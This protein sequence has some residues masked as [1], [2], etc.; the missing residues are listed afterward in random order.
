MCYVAAPG[1]LSRFR[2]CSIAA[3]RLRGETPP[4]TPSPIDETGGSERGGVPVDF[5]LSEPPVPHRS[6]RDPVGPADTHLNTLTESPVILVTHQ[7]G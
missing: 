4:A 3:A 2:R 6:G 7:A 1:T 5:R